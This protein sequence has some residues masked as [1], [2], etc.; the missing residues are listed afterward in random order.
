VRLRYIFCI[1]Y[2]FEKY[3]AETELIVMIYWV[4]CQFSIMSA[5]A[6]KLSLVRPPKKKL[7]SGIAAK[8]PMSRKNRSCA[9]ALTVEH[10]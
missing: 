4:Y 2:E 6:V 8:A 1:P 9:Q 3:I 7:F 10:S 5:V